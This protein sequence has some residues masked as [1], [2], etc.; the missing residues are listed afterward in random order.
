MIKPIDERKNSMGING[1]IN[2]GMMK[3]SRDKEISKSI[4]ERN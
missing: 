3:I 4:I 2:K 1:R